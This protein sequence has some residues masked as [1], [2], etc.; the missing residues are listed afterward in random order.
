LQQAT[1]V[2][3]QHLPIHQ[4]DAARRAPEQGTLGLELKSLDPLA[5][6]RLGQVEPTLPLV[7][8]AEEA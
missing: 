2:A 1:R 5:H 8:I 7:P 3:E 4:R 6:R